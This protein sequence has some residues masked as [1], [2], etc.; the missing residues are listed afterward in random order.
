M[1]GRLKDVA[2]KFDEGERN[3]QAK[4]RK[5]RKE[6]EIELKRLT[7]LNEQLF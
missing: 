2:V 6:M 1:H 5:A 7:D 4:L 3:R